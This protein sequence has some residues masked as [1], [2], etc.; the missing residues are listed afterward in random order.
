MNFIPRFIMPYDEELLFSWIIRLADANCFELRSFIKEYIS[1]EKK[2]NKL[3]YDCRTIFLPIC[4]HSRIPINIQEQFEQHSTFNLDGMV[5]SGLQQTGYINSIFRPDEPLNILSNNKITVLRY[6]P[7]CAEYEIQQGLTSYLHVSHNLPGVCVCSKH[8]RKLKQFTGT[9]SHE[10]EFNDSNYKEIDSPNTIEADLAYAQYVAELNRTN[11]ACNIKDIKTIV[12]SRLQE[13]NYSSKDDYQ[14]LQ[15]AISKWEYKSLLVVDVN[16]FLRGKLSST[17]NISLIEIIPLLM[18][19][20]PNVYDLIEKLRIKPVLHTF[21]C[22]ECGHQYV[23]T[24]LSQKQG[25]G[26]P[27]CNMK[28]TPDEVFERIVEISTDGEYLVEGASPH[29]YSEIAL[30]HKKCE[31]VFNMNV[32]SFLYEGVRCNCA[33]RMPLIDAKKT[34]EKNGEFEIVRFYSASRPVS[35]RHKK[36]GHTFEYNFGHFSNN[37]QCKLCH[38]HNGQEMQPEVYRAKV[39]ELVGEEYIVVQ[40]FQSRDKKVVLRHTACGHEQE[41]WPKHFLDGQRC[42]HCHNTMSHEELLSL[43][44]EYGQGRYK[45]VDYNKNLYTL[46]DTENNTEIKLSPNKIRQ[47]ITRPTMSDILPVKQ[48]KRIKL[49]G[50]WDIGFQH[51][52]QY[53]EEYGHVN[54]PKRKVYKGYNLGTWCQRQRSEFV[55][56]I[57]HKNRTKKLREIGFEFDVRE[58]EWNRRYEQYARHIQQTG[59]PEIA[60]RVEFEGD[61][62]GMWVDTQRRNKNKL[63]PERRNKLKRLNPDMFG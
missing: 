7:E 46:L 27:E 57:L 22:P 39:K 30:Y 21:I 52:S 42:R 11:L 32:R 20:F 56:G 8:H 17:V 9:W 34:I 2:Y 62:L 5:M 40:D 55:K 3:G 50:S 37:P 6:C 24:K 1:P 13:L 19:L 25:W 53:K 58:G 35:I 41:Y 23:A 4:Q 28:L 43:I 12:F 48:K 47:E 29:E 63:S 60:R 59:S 31:T 33:N 14:S 54:V 38:S 44:Q 45:V 26:C 15:N 16:N 18:F 61:K 51:L 10:L 36:C 49:L